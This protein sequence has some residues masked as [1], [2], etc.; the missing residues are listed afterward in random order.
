[1][2]TSK[3]EKSEEVD[4]IIS[5]NGSVYYKGILL[6]KITTTNVNGQPL[7]YFQCPN[8]RKYKNKD[9]TCSFKAKILNFPKAS[10]IEIITSHSRECS[11]FSSLIDK[12]LCTENNECFKFQDTISNTS[13]IHSFTCEKKYEIKST[14]KNL[15]KTENQ[16]LKK[17]R[18]RCQE[19]ESSITESILQKKD[20]NLKIIKNYSNCS[21]SD[22]EKASTKKNSNEEEAKIQQEYFDYILNV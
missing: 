18:E 6:K 7:T 14:F 12:F 8:S 22:S 5:Q 9:A 21:N 13:N 15:Q 2:N 19:D 4:C 3:T 16:M 20:E 1:M 17:K 10:N 11:F